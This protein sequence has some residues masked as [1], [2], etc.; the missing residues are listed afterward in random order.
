MTGGTGLC[1]APL[2]EALA[3]RG[4]QVVIL[5]RAMRAGPDGLEFLGGRTTSP[6]PWTEALEGC[7]AVIHLAGE[8]IPSWSFGT[9]HRRRVAE[10]RAGGTRALV[11]ALAAIPGPRRPRALLSASSVDVYPFDL[12]DD[13][14]AEDAPAGEH[15]LAGLCGHWEG[16]ALAAREAGIRTAVLRSGI[17]IGRGQRSF[18]NLA[19]PW[20]LFFRGPLGDGEQW[21]SWVHVD[22]VVAAYLHVLDGG[23]S[24]PVNVVAPGA[25]RQGDFARAVAAVLG[26]RVWN[27]L[28]ADSLRELLGGLAETMVNGRRAVPLALER[29]GFRF[30]RA[31]A[32]AALAASLEPE[33]DLAPAG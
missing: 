14:Y 22:D 5:S 8:P 33:D 13:R 4:D 2:A 12:G 28:D 9:L 10:S 1:G 6:G 7:D 25:I 3:A 16:E 17:V 15:F 20:K 18:K 32:P 24:G 27:P 21:F 26:R 30:L 31:D 19:S 23:L 29:D 11:E